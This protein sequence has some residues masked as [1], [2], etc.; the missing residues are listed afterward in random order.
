MRQLMVANS[1]SNVTVNRVPTTSIA[2]FPNLF[3]LVVP[4]EYPFYNDVLFQGNNDTLKYLE[5]CMDTETANMLN[6]CRVFD[7]KHKRLRTVS[8]RESNRAGGRANVPINELSKVLTNM[9]RSAEKLVL[10]SSRLITSLMVAV[11][12][13]NYFTHVR[14]LELRE[15]LLSLA[16]VLRLLKQFPALVKF[17]CGIAELGDELE[18][19]DL[20]KLPDYIVSSY[21]ETGKLL[22]TWCTKYYSKLFDVK[23]AD[24]ALLLALVCPK[25]R[26]VVALKANVP[27]FNTRLKDAIQSG[28]YRKYAPQLSRLYCIPK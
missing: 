22:Q 28:P 25:L 12:N 3:M 23:T 11:H 19:V 18:H 24:I 5:L 17:T 6:R 26:R 16:Y 15:G 10:S 27:D 9:A 4:L 20:D 21:G 2:P 7:G 1:M 14:L 8:I 13:N